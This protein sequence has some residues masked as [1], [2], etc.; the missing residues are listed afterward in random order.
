[1]SSCEAG[2]ANV[3]TSGAL[4]SADAGAAADADAGA[5]ASAIV[6]GGCDEMS[7]GWKRRALPFWPKSLAPRGARRAEIPRGACHM[8][9]PPGAMTPRAI[10]DA[11]APCP[12]YM[13][14]ATALC[15]SCSAKVA[16]VLGPSERT[17]AWRCN[18]PDQ[19]TRH[20]ICMSD[21]VRRPSWLFDVSTCGW[22]GERLAGWLGA[23]K[24]NKGVGY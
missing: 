4:F 12:A 11:P 3:S 19:T 6:A 14:L 20:H 15:I 7:H 17:H 21:R 8:A 24:N 5:R 22:M 1:M 23:Y 16:H 10:S 18:T 13:Y 2:S 9:D